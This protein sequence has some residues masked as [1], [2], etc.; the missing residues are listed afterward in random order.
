M[1]AEGADLTWWDD[2]GWSEDAL[3]SDVWMVSCRST[4]SLNRFSR[5]TLIYQPVLDN[6]C[7]L[8]QSCTRIQDEIHGTIYSHE[9]PVYDRAHRTRLLN[10]TSRRRPRLPRVEKAYVL[11]K[12]PSFGE[13]GGADGVPSG[14]VCVVFVHGE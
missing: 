7:E 4:K 8:G 5:R 13:M 9:K 1:A 14:K 6:V 11:R 12:G 2:A 10:S 3:D